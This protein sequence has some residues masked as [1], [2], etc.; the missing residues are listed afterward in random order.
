MSGESSREQL[1]APSDAFATTR[2]SL[3]A[4]AGRGE[5]LAAQQALAQLCQ[6]YW[7]PLYAFVRRRVGS[8]HESQ[9]LTQAYFAWLLEKNTVAAA[10]R[11]RGRFRAFLLASLKNFLANEWE[12]QRAQKRGGGQAALSL[13]FDAGESRFRLEPLDQLTPER[14]FDKQWAMTLLEQVLG[15]LRQEY[16]DA[17]KLPQFEVLKS[18]LAGNTGEY[19]EAAAQ[20]GLTENAVRVAA[21]RLRQR[22]RERLRAEIA[23]TVAG[24]EEVDDEIRRLFEVLGA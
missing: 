13:D 12:K 7:Y 11:E 22:Y 17:D 23:Q 5:P 4:A 6:A 24:P 3:V 9:D 15:G 1:P 19:A 14:L 21:H 2:W 18:F 10:D 20:L 16:A 8:P